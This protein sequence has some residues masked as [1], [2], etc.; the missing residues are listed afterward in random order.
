MDKDE[1][2][3]QPPEGP[4]MCSNNCGF[5]GSATNMNL[6][7]RCYRNYVLE[8]AKS[9]DV[10][11]A[12]SAVKSEDAVPVIESNIVEESTSSTATSTVEP[13]HKQQ[14]NRCF[15]CRKRVGLASFKCRCGNQFCALHRYHD[16]HNCPYDYRAAARDAIAKANPVIKAEKIDKI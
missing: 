5:F 4:I 16:K 7:S 9:T 10:A 14:P 3:C 11:A 2:G 6:C 8:Q 13:P 12:L 15:T 1:T